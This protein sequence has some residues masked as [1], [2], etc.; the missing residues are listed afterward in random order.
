[1]E[2][3]G[4]IPSPNDK[5]QVWAALFNVEAWK[6]SIEQME[7]YEEVG[8]NLY[9]M[10]VNVEIG[11]IKGTQ[12]MQLEFS[13]LEPP[14]SCNFEV[15]NKLIKS[16]KGRFQLT[17][18]VAAEGETLPEGTKTLLKYTLDVDAGNPIFNAILKSAEDKLKEGVEWILGEVETK[19]QELD[20]A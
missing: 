19:A 1:M 16:A 4:S 10:V 2:L 7:K 9:D 18:A 8:E 17:D 3:T 13:E 12:E 20:A 11:P 5:E 6:A 14:N 15:K